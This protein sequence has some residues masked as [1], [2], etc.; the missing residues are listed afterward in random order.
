M[1]NEDTNWRFQLPAYIAATMGLILIGLGFVIPI[2]APE[3]GTFQGRSYFILLGC[4]GFALLLAAFGTRGE[5]KYRGLYVTGA[6]AIAIILYILLNP[7]TLGEITSQLRSGPIDGGSAIQGYLSGKFDNLRAVVMYA[8]ND[9]IYGAF[10]F[11]GSHVERYGFEVKESHFRSTY[12]DCFVVNI[13][14]NS[15]L[16]NNSEKVASKRLYVP[17]SYIGSLD[18]SSDRDSRVNWKQKRIAW[19]YDGKNI[20][21][22]KNVPIGVESCNFAAPIDKPL[23]SVAS[24]TKVGG[25]SL[26]DAAHA[27]EVGANP[28]PVSDSE[29][30]Q[31]VIDGLHADNALAQA[32]AQ[33][34]VV[35]ARQRIVPAL[36]SWFAQSSRSER[37]KNDILTILALIGNNADESL[38]KLVR[39]TISNNAAIFFDLLIDESRTVRG[40]ATSLLYTAADFSSVADLVSASKKADS[41]D[42]RTNVALVLAGIFDRVDSKQRSSIAEMI[43]P[44]AFQSGASDLL[45]SIIDASASNANQKDKVGWIFYGV[46]DDPNANKWS[47]K[48]FAKPGSDKAPEVGDLVQSQAK[49][50][51]R[52]NVIEM[53]DKGWVNKP[54]IGLVL[55]K[56]KYHVTDV[57]EVV[58]GYWWARVRQYSQ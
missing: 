38:E 12:E 40:N 14:E 53:S 26:F 55:P 18:V 54:A 2:L 43:K 30:L 46:L 27:E 9:P 20:L 24:P 6:G 21:S 32:A 51:L 36:M 4:V 31:S 17:A 16:E 41:A 3:S 45:H 22:S 39:P 49:V 25:L 33:K 5:V 34:Q 1:T 11:A 29:F 44:I 15:S 48:Y 50:N 28:A 10:D 23:S 52:Q 57:K 35:E 13:Y 7:K 58:D 8:H 56:E 19:Q 47:Q 37:D 42:K